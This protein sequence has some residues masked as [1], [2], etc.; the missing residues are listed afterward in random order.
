MED[1]NITFYK[2]DLH[3]IFKYKNKFAPIVWSKLYSKILLV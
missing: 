3:K 2:V 1:N